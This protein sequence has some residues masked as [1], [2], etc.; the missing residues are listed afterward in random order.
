MSQYNFFYNELNIAQAEEI[1]HLREV[2]KKLSAKNKFENFI[3]K[4]FT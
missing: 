4:N 2:F 1:S 3:Y